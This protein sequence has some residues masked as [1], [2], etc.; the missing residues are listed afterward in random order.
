[1][2]VDEYAELATYAGCRGLPHRN[3]ELLLATLCAFTWNAHF[4][5]KGTI[6]KTPSDFLREA[7]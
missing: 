4:V 7:D 2:G 1:M 5:A 3:V 6:G